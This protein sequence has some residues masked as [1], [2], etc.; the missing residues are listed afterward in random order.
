MDYLIKKKKNGREKKMIFRSHKEIMNNRI[1]GLMAFRVGGKGGG[2]ESYAIE[3]P[4]L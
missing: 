1:G 2:P 4:P 3:C